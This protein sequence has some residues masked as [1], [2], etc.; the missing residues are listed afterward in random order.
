M[1]ER[2]NEAI[3]KIKVGRGTVGDQI[4][5]GR[6]LERLRK[7]VALHEF[8]SGKAFV[9]TRWEE[10]QRESKRLQKELDEAR[11]A[12]REIYR[13]GTSLLTFAERWPWLEEGE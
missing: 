13:D 4:M 11:E 8:R 3:E 7:Q 12:A 5:V 10:A 1:D 9:E 2:V 6:E